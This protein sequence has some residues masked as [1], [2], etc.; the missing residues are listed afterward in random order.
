[1][2]YELLNEIAKKNKAAVAAR[3]ADDI[4][5]FNI[6]VDEIEAT[7]D[8]DTGQ[9]LDFVPPTGFR[10][11]YDQDDHR[12]LVLHGKHDDRY[13]DIA[14]P[15]RFAAVMLQVVEERLREGWYTDYATR[16][17]EPDL[18]SA[19]FLERFSV[20]PLPDATPKEKV[21]FWSREKTN[22][23]YLDAIDDA[24]ILFWIHR[25]LDIAE[26]ETVEFLMTYLLR[27]GSETVKRSLR[28][29]NPSTP[30]MK[31]IIAAIPKADEDTARDIIAARDGAQGNADIRRAGR[32]AYKLLLSRKDHQYERFTIATIG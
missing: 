32:L 15:D 17:E 24:R 5:A 7:R 2:N 6:L 22:W 18:L 3:D 12:V 20:T 11:M 19:F 10:Q 23:A 4:D 1:M 31:A 29:L 8:P 25:C 9:L 27:R 13:F 30:T 16:P 14:S 28:S 21:A 26:P